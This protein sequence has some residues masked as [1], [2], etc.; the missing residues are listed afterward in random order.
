MIDSIKEIKTTN[1]F[2]ELSQDQK[3]CQ[4][5]ETFENCMTSQLLK[6]GENSCGCIPY[7]LVNFSDF[8]HVKYF[9]Q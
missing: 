4:T 9:T 7:E 6:V 8:S 3:N 5:T 2:H 1:T